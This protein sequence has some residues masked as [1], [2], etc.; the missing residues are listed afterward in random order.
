MWRRLAEPSVRRQDLGFRE[1]PFGRITTKEPSL[2]GHDVDDLGPACPEPRVRPSDPLESGDGQPRADVLELVRPGEHVEIPPPRR[3]GP[4]DEQPVLH[5][6]VDDL[7]GGPARVRHARIIASVGMRRAS[8]VASASAKR[9]LDSPSPASKTPVTIRQH[10]VI[11]RSYAWLIVASILLAA[12]GAA[13][14][15]FLLPRTYEAEARLYVGQSIEDRRIDVDGLEASRL[16]ADT[17][18][19]LALS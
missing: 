16:I 7:R 15:T 14:A 11:L 6:R 1:Q 10:L 4:E 5:R 19:Q 13:V 18:A 9:L 17:Y 12:I 8:D 2:G 3:K